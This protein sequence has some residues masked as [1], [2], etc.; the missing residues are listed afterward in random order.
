MLSTST[1]WGGQLPVTLYALRMKA[2]ARYTI[3][4][5]LISAQN[6]RGFRVV[7]SAREELPGGATADLDP[8]KSRGDILACR[9]WEAALH[10]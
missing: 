1:T 6:G 3:T 9:E 8:V 4:Q 5:D 2:G 7:R 10:R